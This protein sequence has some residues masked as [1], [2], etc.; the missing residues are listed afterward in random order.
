MPSCDTD[1]SD[2]NEPF[3]NYTIPLD[4]DGSLSKCDVY[5]F[6]NATKSLLRYDRALDEGSQ[7]PADLFD[8]EQTMG[9]PQGWVYDRDLFTSSTVMEVNC[10][11]YV[12]TH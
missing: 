3:V 12:F 4:G 8:D 10:S 6:Y 2:Y 1:Q 11:I 5:S 7:C 9:C